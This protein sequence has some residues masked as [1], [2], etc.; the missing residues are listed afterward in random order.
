ML[1]QVNSMVEIIRECAQVTNEDIHSVDWLFL[2]S[3]S[4]YWLKTLNTI[5]KTDAAKWIIV[6]IVGKEYLK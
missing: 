1:E 2:I 5:G 3:Q 4:I 6:I